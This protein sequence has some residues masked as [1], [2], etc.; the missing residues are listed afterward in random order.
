MSSYFES[1]PS[2]VP[3]KLLDKLWL[4][5]D[6]FYLIIEKLSF[7]ISAQRIIHVVEL[8]LSNTV[9]LICNLLFKS[10]EKLNH[11]GSIYCDSFNIIRTLVYSNVKLSI[12]LPQLNNFF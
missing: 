2:F 8:H 11:W 6:P 4:L 3:I 9:F 7:I 12:H 1:F 5:T 10:F